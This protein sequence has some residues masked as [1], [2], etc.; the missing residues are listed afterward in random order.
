LRQN[1]YDDIEVLTYPMADSDR[2]SAQAYLKLLRASLI[3]ADDFRIAVEESN[4]QFWYLGDEPASWYRAALKLPR[5]KMSAL[6]PAVAV[7]DRM[8][9]LPQDFQRAFDSSVEVSFF[10]KPLDLQGVL[11]VDFKDERAVSEAVRQVGAEIKAEIAKLCRRYMFV[12]DLTNERPDFYE[13]SVMLKVDQ[14]FLEQDHGE[15]FRHSVK[16]TPRIVSG[17]ARLLR[18]SKVILEI[19]NESEDEIGGVTIQVRAPSDSLKSAI[20]EYM[21]FS[22]GKPSTQ[23]IQFEV[24][25]SALPYCP[26]EVRFLPNEVNLNLKYTPFPIPAILDVVEK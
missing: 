14:R 10:P 24:T 15:I 12:N 21:D 5:E 7:L 1:L 25:P 9:M 16:L 20:S 3:K 4:K 8:V 13:L 11:L 23:K 6:F 18:K 19:Q 22:P 17:P 26:L 2:E